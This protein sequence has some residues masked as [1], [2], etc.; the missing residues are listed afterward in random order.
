M[1]IITN[2]IQQDDGTTTVV[3]K[4]VELS[5]KDF[6]LLD[7]DLEV[8]CNVDVLDP[9][10]IT[11]KQRRKIFAMLRDIYDHFAQPIEYLRYMFQKQLELLNGYEPISLSNCA[12]RQA[13]ELIELILDFVFE[14]NIPMRK[15]TSGLMSND[16]YFL[17]KCTVNRVCVICGAQNAELAHR[18]AVG[19]GR[20]RKHINHKD[21]QVLALCHDHHSEQHRIGMDSFN[22]KYHL[23][24]SWV[25]VDNKLNTMLKGG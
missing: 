16:K 20:N 8:E 9:Y 17:Y 13:T 7:N 15:H 25:N 22:K 14:H 10:Q 23:T 3:V 18:Y 2:Y 1:P 11:D 4:D 21:N 24:N 6:L 19:S 5:N 12:R